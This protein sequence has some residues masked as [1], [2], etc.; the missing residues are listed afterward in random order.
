[1]QLVEQHII[2]DNDEFYKECD[3][4]CFKVKNLYNSSLY[5][6]R[7]EWIKNK[8]NVLNKLYHLIKN[9]SDYKALP[10]KVSS[11]VLLMVNQN[12]K[13]F[14]KALESY[15]KFP[16]LFKARPNLP[17]YLDKVDGRFITSYTNQAISK[18]VFDK[19]GKIKLS[20]SNIEFK[21]KIEDFS[22][23]DCV[24]I[25]PKICYMESH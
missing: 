21:T 4:L 17:H 12:F 2:K 15:N 7:Q 5:I 11:S 18:K 16:H 22:I 14:F 20:Q 9:S 19:Q 13:S 24:R 1:M 8:V 6:V 3:E 23:I 10:A 25:V